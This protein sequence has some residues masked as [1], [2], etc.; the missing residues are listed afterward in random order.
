MPLGGMGMHISKY[1]PAE[2]QAEALN[3]IKWFEQPDVQKKWAAA[4]GVPARKDALDVARVP[5]RRPVEPGLRRLR[6][7]AA[8]HVE[9]AGVREAA[10]TSRTPTST[11]R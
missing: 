5:R 6:A 10:S 11:R 7:A 1:A 4:G 3:F 8:R 2:D 9:R